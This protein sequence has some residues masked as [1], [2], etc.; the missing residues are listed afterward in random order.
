VVTTYGQATKDG[1]QTAAHR[2]AAA[3]V[4]NLAYPCRVGEA[5]A[6][7]FI[8]D[9]TSMSKI[10]KS[11]ITAAVLTIGVWSASVTPSYAKPEYAKTE[12]KACGYCHVT[13]GKP[14]LNAAGDYYAA[15]EH[16]LKGYT[17]SN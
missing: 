12:G 16:S 15:H 4:C 5:I 6:L 8:E 14:E 1:H 7:G 10:L 3:P 11:A 17:P 2:T 13:S 9:T